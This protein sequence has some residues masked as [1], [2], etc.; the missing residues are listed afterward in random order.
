MFKK[1]VVIRAK[2]LKP[3]K[4]DYKTILFF[5]L[6]ICGVIIGISLIKN[7]DN[8]FNRILKNLID[9]INT[10]KNNNSFLSGT[11][12][13]FGWLFVFVLLAFFSGLSGLGIPFISLVNVLFGVIC[14]SFCG[15]YYVNYGMKGIGFFSLV[16]L[17]CYAITAA[18]LIKCCCESLKISFNVFSF[19]SGNTVNQS[20]NKKL[21][22][23]YIFSYLILSIPLILASIL[24]IAGFKLFSGLFVDFII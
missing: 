21:L 3:L 8:D 18:T 17:P 9:G 15:I 20:K 16:Y 22:K 14:G 10:T 19:L 7:S 11:F 2:R 4:L 24:N 23:D 13:V 6:M 12:Y 1:S 5:T